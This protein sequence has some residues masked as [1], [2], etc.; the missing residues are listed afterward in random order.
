MKKLAVFLMAIGLLCSAVGAQADTFHF[1]GNILYNTDVVQFAFNLANDATN[2]R[3]WTDSFQNGANF[4]PVTALWAAAAGIGNLI[5]TNDDND[6]V[7]PA[8]QTPFDSGFIVPSLAAGDYIFSMAAFDNFPK[9]STLVEGFKY[10]GTTPVSITSWMI[11]A[12]GYY[13]VWLDG[14]DQAHSSAVPIPGAIW[15]L[16]SGLL[17][18]GGLRRKFRK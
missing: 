7:N 11:N 12:P 17:G 9:G 13:S 18:M 2:V 1:T 6:T 3:L 16:G 15:L 14:V 8:T 5:D 10:D 4:D